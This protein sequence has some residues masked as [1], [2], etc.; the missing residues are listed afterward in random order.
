MRTYRRFL[1]TFKISDEVINFFASY[2]ENTLR[3]LYLKFFSDLNEQKDELI[4][5]EINTRSYEI[6]NLDP[7]PYREKMKEIYDRLF[8]NYFKYINNSLYEYGVTEKYYENNL[9]KTK[10]E[11]KDGSSEIVVR[12]ESK[13]V[14]DNLNKLVFKATN[15]KQYVNTLPAFTDTENIINEYKNRLNIDYKDIKDQIS[16]NKYSDTIDAFLKDKLYNLTIILNNY[17]DTILFDFSTLKDQV[18]SSISDIKDLVDT[19][20]DITAKIMN[21]QYKAISDSTVRIDKT[22]NI[23]EEH[24]ERMKYIQKTEN[25]MTTVRA[26]IEKIKDYAEFKFD[27]TLDGNKFKIPKI[28]STII[29]KIIPKDIE[30]IVAT[31]YSFCY[32]KSFSFNFGLTDG[33][34]TSVLEFDTKSSLITINT[35]TNIEGYKYTIKQVEIKGY[36]NTEVINVENYFYKPFC[37]D[38]VR[39]ITAGFDVDI[40]DIIE[41][42]TDIINK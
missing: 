27:F 33:N 11:N 38:I 3:P 7:L 28:K 8:E 1:S 6:E 12:R 22:I 42:K 9:N 41:N 40:P 39:N 13:Y 36:M 30:I 16:Q 32:N 29:D 23:D 2:S 31:D 14:E 10:T 21:K 34:F 20:L 4:K 26:Y 18:T 15:V 19:I 5:S 25:M 24:D 17:Y 37:T 35:Y